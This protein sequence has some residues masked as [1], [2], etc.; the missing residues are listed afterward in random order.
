M[1]L[2]MTLTAK[3]IQMTITDD[4]DDIVLFVKNKILLLNVSIYHFDE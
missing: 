1:W 3:A 4:F 2:G